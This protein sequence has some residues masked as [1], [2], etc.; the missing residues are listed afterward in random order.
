MEVKAEHMKRIAKIFTES[1]SD[2]E[3]MKEDAAFTAPKAFIAPKPFIAPST[4]QPKTIEQPFKFNLNAGQKKY[5]N[6]C[7]PVPAEVAQNSSNANQMFKF[8]REQLDKKRKL[9]DFDP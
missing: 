8:K 3:E 4:V 9:E 6:P 5:V 2:N 7:L 1:S